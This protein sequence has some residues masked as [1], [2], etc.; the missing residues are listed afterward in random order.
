MNGGAPGNVKWNT[1]DTQADAKIIW[2]NIVWARN[3]AIPWAAAPRHD[4]WAWRPVVIEL[5]GGMKAMCCVPPTTH[6]ILAVPTVWLPGDYA[7]LNRVWILQKT[8]VE[9]VKE[10]EAEVY[11]LIGKTR[12]V[13]DVIFGEDFTKSE[14]QVRMRAYAPKH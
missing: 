11:Q 9:G 10:A 1:S 7:D 8:D 14:R 3:R 4:L 12:L 6:F 13:G 2:D 5:V